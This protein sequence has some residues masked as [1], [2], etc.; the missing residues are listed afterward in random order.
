[1]KQV[2]D[3]PT[4]IRGN[5][6]D[7]CYLSDSLAKTTKVTIQFTYYSDHA[8]LSVELKNCME[9]EWILD[10]FD[11]NEQIVYFWN[12]SIFAI[13]NNQSIFII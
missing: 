9:E 12:K 3:Q 10:I 5:T 1:M 4:Q 13:K 11:I 2:V 8:S 7:H 6:I